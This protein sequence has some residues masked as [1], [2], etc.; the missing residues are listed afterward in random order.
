[1]QTKQKLKNQFKM[2]DKTHKTRNI[3]GG[4]IAEQNY[5]QFQSERFQFPRNKWLLLFAEK[6]WRLHYFDTYF[7]W[8]QKK[9]GIY[10][11]A[12]MNK[13]KSLVVNVTREL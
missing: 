13:K 5:L 2:S 6:T 7:V 9:G 8:E 12:G 3:V 10:Y 4:T 11:Y 1:M